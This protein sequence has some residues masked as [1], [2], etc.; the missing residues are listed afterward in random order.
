MFKTTLLRTVRFLMDRL[1]CKVIREIKDRHGNLYFRR[2]AYFNCKWLGICKHE[3][4][5][6]EG[7]ELYD[8][9]PYLHNHPREFWTYVVDG[10]YTEIKRDDAY[11]DAYEGDRTQGFFG[12]VDDKCFH[13]IKTLLNKKY[14]RTLSIGLTHTGK[15][16]YLTGEGRVISNED[17][18]ANKI[19]EKKA[20]RAELVDTLEEYLSHNSQD[21][22]VER[23]PLRDKLKQLVKEERNT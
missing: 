14:A 7:D 18:R 2:S 4:W 10:G 20:K 19:K 3:F 1:P 22:R 6:M 17:Y 8:K 16:G 11:C 15:W 21:G 9:D 5:Q 13:Q 23:Q 12:F